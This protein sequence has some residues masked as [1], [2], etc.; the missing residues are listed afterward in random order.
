MKN[1]I[2]DSNVWYDILSGNSNILNTLKATGGKLCVTPINILEIASK[3]DSNNFNYR[4]N[5][6]KAIMDYAD[7]YL[8]SNEV[9]LARYWGFK[10]NDEVHWKE[11][12]LTLLRAPSYNDLVNGYIDPIDNVK[13]KQDLKLLESWREYHYKDFNTG[14]INAIQ[15]IHPKYMERKADGNLKKHKKSKN[16]FEV[17]E[18]DIGASILACYERA[19]VV[20][21]DNRIKELSKYKDKVLFIE[22]GNYLEVLKNKM[23]DITEETFIYFDPPYVNKAKNL[24]NFYFMENDH[25]ILRDYIKKLKSNWLLSYDYDTSIENL[26]KDSKIFQKGCFEVTYTI[27]ESKRNKIKEFLASNINL[28]DL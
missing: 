8:M 14:I 3:V 2:C 1:I 5:V 6:A 11:A 25:I 24:Y 17:K 22:E 10:V 27:S 18:E 16:L 7:R 28:S 4:Q 9:Y 23:E 15:S 20:A 13:R 12:V 26:Y 21:K 19:K